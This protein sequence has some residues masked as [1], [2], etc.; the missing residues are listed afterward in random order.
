ME[1]LKLT[2]VVSKFD[3]IRD[4][5]DWVE[6]F[7][8]AVRL[9]GISQKDYADMCAILLEGPALNVYRQLPDT[10]KK[11]HVKIID[12][13]KKAFGP[14]MFESHDKFVNRKLQPGEAPDTFMADL[15]SYARGM[16]LQ[17][18][19]V[20]R[21]LICQFVNGLPTEV[22]SMVRALCTEKSTIS[23]VVDLAKSIIANQRASGGDSYLGAA[24]AIN[25]QLPR[26]QRCYQCSGFGHIAKDC[27]EPRRKGKYY[28]VRCRSD[29][30]SARF[31]NAPAP[32]FESNQSENSNR[33]AAN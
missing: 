13:L 20:S 3:G 16:F 30:H 24:A 6:K 17:E 23:E 25:K 10:D 31:C 5:D 29:G 15:K 21:L 19:S 8:L 18:H 7:L 1:S 28:C 11:D 22:A 12:A 4:V 33:E 9:R 14:T 2:D 32:V 27:T 26:K